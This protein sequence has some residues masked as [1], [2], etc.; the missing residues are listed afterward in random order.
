MEFDIPLKLT[1]LETPQREG[2]LG[3]KA[4]VDVAGMSDA[5]ANDLVEQTAYD[6]CENDALCVLEQDVFDRAY[7]CARDFA[8]LKPIGRIRITDALCS[9]L[10]VLSASVASLLASGAG[11][12][13]DA[14]D[15]VASHRE[16]LKAY[17]CLVHHVADVADA[18]ARATAGV[19]AATSAPGAGKADKKAAKKPKGAPLVEWKWEE[20]RERV[21][22]V[23]AGVLDADLWNLFRPRQPSEAFLG[24]FTKLGCLALES[25]PALRS[26]ITKNAAFSM[27]GA[28]ALKWGQLE[29]VTTALVHLLNK[30]EHLPGPIAECAAIAAD[31]FEN[32]R[33]AAALLREV[34][35]VDPA[36]YKRQQLSD[37]KGVSAVGVFVAELAQR[38]PKTTMTNI[39]LLLPH[40]DG[41]A[42]S[43]RSALVTVLG[44]LICS[45]ASSGSLTEE[46]DRSTS[47]AS[48][49]LLRAKQGFLDLLVERVHDVSAFTRARVLQTWA[50]MAEKK[51]V[52]LSHWLVVADLAIGRL[53]DKSA[54][55]RKAAMH[56]LAVMLGFNPFAPQLPSSAFASSL[57]EYEAK[58]AQMAPPPPETPEA[59]ETVPEG[60]EEPARQGD[61]EHSDGKD[62]KDEED[63]KEPS[64]TPDDKTQGATENETPDPPTQ[65]ELDGGVE[66]VRTM[67]AALK[68]ALGFAVQMG[69][70]VG[71]LCRLLSS[72][73]PSDAIEAT[74]LLVR[75]RQF[76]VDGA[77]EGVRRMLGLVFSRDVAV[78]DAAVEAVDVLFLSGAD[79]PVAAAA[80]LAEVA[81]ASALGELAA[82][83]EVIKLLVADGRVPPDGAV[84]RATWALATAREA[85]DAARA[86]AFT[87][88][89]MAAATA[90]EVVVPHVDHAAAALERACRVGDGALARAAAA[91]LARARP[92]GNAGTK[93]SAGVALPA[94]A[95]DGVVFAALAKVLS[96]GSSLSGRA[97]YPAAEQS[98]AALYALHPD[99]EGAA[100]D[101][102]RSFAAAAFNPKKKD[103]DAES[104]E[105][106]EGEDAAG[107][108]SEAETE[109]ASLEKKAPATSAASAVDAAQLSRFLFVLGEVGL[110]H[111]VHVEGL[112]RAVRRARVARDRAAAEASEAAAAAGKS[113]GEEAELAAALGQGAVGEDLELDNARE[114][115]EAELLAFH[116]AKE[117]RS[118]QSGKGLVAAYAP[119]VVA[120][121]GH[122]AVAEG[123]PLLRGAALAALSRL[124]AIDGG[125][126]EEHL[127][128]IFTRLRDESDKGTR[129][130]LMVALG[131]LAFRFPNAV[132]PWTEHLYGLREWG[133]SLHD[134]DSGVR[135]H[136]ITVLAHL[137]LNDMMKVKGHIAEMARCL[138]DPDPRVAA[139][140]K[141]LF[142]ELSRKHGNP[143]YNLLPD[144]LS[145]L[146]GDAA[147][148]P[149]AFQSI[150]TRLLGFIDKDRQTEALADK[151]VHRFAEAALAPTPKPARDVAFCI[152]ALALSDKAFKKFMDAWKLYEPAL[153]DR[154][155]FKHLDAVVAK[156]KKTY[157]GK[158]KSGRSDGADADNSALEGPKK[159]IEDFERKMAAAHVERFESYRS[160]RRAEGHVFDDDDTPAVTLGGEEGE[161]EAPLKAT[162][163]SENDGN[164][165]EEEEE[166]DAALPDLTAS[167]A[168]AAEEATFVPTDD[169]RLDGASKDALAETTENDLP[170]EPADANDVP[171]EPENDENSPD[172]PEPEPAPKRGRAAAA[173]KEKKPTKAKKTE[174]TDAAP[175]RSSRRALRAK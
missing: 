43:L 121:C 68:T 89:A 33:L 131:D 77:D 47:D 167:G 85:S 101:V 152:S 169:A 95:P 142:A 150:M 110:R 23:M 135:Q 161:K 134:P 15:V 51:A 143:I 132:E 53:G 104:T 103:A 66:A 94:L 117:A 99:P 162:R 107:G 113:G 90:P 80:A 70:A 153:Y 20:Q 62:E 9:N 119:V 54:L 44:H 98:I 115:C 35:S 87:V 41:E 36:E 6:L 76:G 78:R 133:N 168:T 30:H 34:A 149:E 141:L 151:F 102:I 145:R 171:D 97:W 42:Y 75:L 19:A 21:M 16:A 24:L 166:E 72:S 111:L 84:V 56:L 163:D 3:P 13:A 48:A 10:S 55:V 4:H 173:K 130:A 92:G 38:M 139:V 129:S 11:D 112:G 86:A 126:C 125:F 172:E 122:P 105:A 160:A 136:A 164:A 165:P 88:L 128:L 8:A 124:M 157:G 2:A 58:L 61:T 159:E 109:E 123:H 137:V 82:L 100:S 1:D 39:S 59:P 40:L 71:V 27:L 22:H 114:A 108:G 147:T 116:S 50:S 17:A 96:P 156:A 91:L 5:E 69:G 120:L 83:E 31:R 74:G 65:P 154:E 14:T 174:E 57:K 79:S 148:S 29:N 155:V 7:A 67:V 146:S 106:K 18:E 52:P 46:R 73:T 118:K 49:P 63:A 93:E 144:L 81:S 175:V 45:D 37:A 60:D 26:K 32:A 64:E 25:Q 28:C 170:D 127:S 12:A 158:N 140:A 138:E